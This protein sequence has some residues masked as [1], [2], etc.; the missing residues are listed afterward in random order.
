MR[1]SKATRRP[2]PASSLDKV[3]LYIRV[4]HSLRSRINQGEWLATE[5]L[6]T[7]GDL[8]SEYSVALITVRLALQVLGAEG[9]VESTR[10][11][12]T[13]VCADVQPV[14]AT[15]GLSTAISDRLEFPANGAMRVISRSV[16]GDLPAYFV[17][18]G[19]GQYPE[20]AVVEKVHTLDDEPFSYVTVMVARHIYEKFPPGADAKAKMLTLILDQGRLKLRR[21]Y[22]QMVVTYADDHLAELL[23]C[24]PLSALVRIRTSR[25][26]TKGKVVLCHDSYYRADRFVYEKEEEGIDLARSS[27]IILPATL[28]SPLGRS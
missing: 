9:L 27:D 16:R 20:Y 13:F 28:S 25:V 10:G 24:T 7:I 3:A 14:A 21:S 11:R 6:P 26:D 2:A 1:I 17:P 15:P 12:G 19:A 18:A 23:H 5:Q 22:I 4:A 8:A